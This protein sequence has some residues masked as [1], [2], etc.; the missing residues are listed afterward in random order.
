VLL[1]VPDRSDHMIRVSPHYRDSCFQRA[2]VSYFSG[3]DMR[4]LW[5]RA[6]TMTCGLSIVSDIAL[7][8]PCIGL[9][10]EDPKLTPQVSIV[11]QSFDGLM[12]STESTCARMESAIRSR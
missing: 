5:D 2:H 11:V 4:S 9:Y 6:A 3:Y 7:R 1:E 10:R 8:M 12:R